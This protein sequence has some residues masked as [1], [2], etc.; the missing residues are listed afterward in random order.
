[1]P[2]ENIGNFPNYKS[3]EELNTA[4]LSKHHL[5]LLIFYPSWFPKADENVTFSPHSSACILT[6]GNP[7]SPSQLLF[8]FTN[9]TDFTVWT[10]S[11][12]KTSLRIDQQ[13]SHFPN[14]LLK[15]LTIFNL[16]PPKIHYT[17]IFPP[18]HPSL[19]EP[20]YS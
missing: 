12:T 4:W 17:H 5:Y 2:G 8:E 6:L 11:S 14:N 18:S 9:L 1:M 19:K 13:G 15:V 10:F 20:F 7:L 3:P 16:A